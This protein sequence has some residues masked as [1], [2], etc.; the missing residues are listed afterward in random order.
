MVDF[1]I[2]D[3][4]GN[5]GFPGEVEAI[6]HYTIDNSDIAIEYECKLLSGAEATI[7]NMTNHS[8]FTV[9]NAE[10]IE[11]TE[12]KLI[13]DKMMEVDDELIPTGK[14]VANKNA[15]NTIVLTKDLAFDNCFVVDD[16]CGID[17]RNQPLKLV[18]EATHPKPTTNSLC[19][20]LNQHS[21]SILVMV[22]IPRVLLKDVVSVLNQVDLLM[23]LTRK[24]GRIKS[25]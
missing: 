25:F 24:N 14:F 12:V 17:T 16:N 15:T 11:G 10:D 21:N 23:L 2:V 22:L 18:L 4:D 9:S 20:P 13:T 19:K 7:V 3:K 8:Y 1:L 5:D 6:V